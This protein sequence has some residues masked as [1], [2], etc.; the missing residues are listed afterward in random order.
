MEEMNIDLSKLIDLIKKNL[1]FII[2]T[3]L[4]CG[5]ITAMISKF[6]IQPK[7]SSSISVYLTNDERSN[8]SVNEDYQAVM[9][10]Q[11]LVQTYDEL[12]KTRKVSQDVVDTLGLSIDP[13]E[14]QKMISLKS[15]GESQFI[16][17]SITTD[18]PTE[19][20]NIANQIVISLKKVSTDIRGTDNVRLVDAATMPE[21]PSS[22]NI[23]KNTL[24]GMIF[25][26]FLALSFIL[27]RSAMDTTVKRTDFI[28]EELGLTVLGTIPKIK[29]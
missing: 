25:G 29:K 14:V 15:M 18:S 5:L 11:K 12:L 8:Q 17:V 19:A 26:V 16:K 1:F 13:S 6:V 23:I 2:I 27:I 9:L 20:Y 7:Y 21:R 22:P 3:T 10:N 4:L 24:I 28:E